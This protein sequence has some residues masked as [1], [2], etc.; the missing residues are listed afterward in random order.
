MRF[1]VIHPGPEFCVADVFTGWVEALEKL[2]QK[3][4]VYNHNIRLGFYDNA[5]M[6]MDPEEEQ[7]RDT[8]V[9][10][11][12]VR[13][14]MP[15]DEALWAAANGLYG[16]CYQTWPDVVLAISAFFTPPLILDV[17]RARK[18]KV[19]LV[20]TESPYQDAEQLM[21][22]A[23]ADYN[24]IN[25]P[26]NLDKFRELGPADYYPHAYRPSVHYPGKGTPKM[27]CDLAFIGT[28][29]SSRIKFFEAMDLEGLDV[30][31]AGNWT[32]LP[33]ES[34]NS[35]LYKYLATDHIENCVDNDQTAE[36]YRSA[37]MG[38]NPYRREIHYEGGVAELSTSIG[39][40][41]VEM[42]ACGLPYLR[43]PR[44]E[45]EEVLGMEPAY[46][47]PEDASEKL[48]WWL[49]HPAKREWAARE[50]YEAIKDRTFENNA[51]RLLKALE[52]GALDA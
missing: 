25:D 37:R 23:H 10:V 20:H 8:S 38:I 24:I 51:K 19:V 13:K 2:G 52:S 49:K 46:D 48:R 42:A 32:K 16:T 4:I 34:P 39:P 21:R 40:R 50:A 7:L 41:E 29:F 6:P 30:L 27:E 31:L 22:G 36:A 44:P 35:P 47:S 15:R 12:K 14:A 1:L 33:V 17:M 26:K 45:N 43:D 3:V 11:R 5:L 18:H 9:G 28:A